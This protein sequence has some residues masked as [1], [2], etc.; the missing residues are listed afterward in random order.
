[1]NTNF[2]IPENV[3]INK[4]DEKSFLLNNIILMTVKSTDAQI[5]KLESFQ[6]KSY[7]LIE[8]CSILQVISLGKEIITV[9]AQLNKHLMQ[10]IASAK[11]IKILDRE[12]D[13]IH[14][15]YRNLLKLSNSFALGSSFSQY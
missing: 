10:G 1:M 9:D 12:E 2:I 3:E 14:Q 11:D 6:S 7:G 4:I 13:L 8:R 5:K 15:F